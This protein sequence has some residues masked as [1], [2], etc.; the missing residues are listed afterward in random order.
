MTVILNEIVDQIKQSTDYQINRRLLREK[1]QT[2]LHFSYNNGLFKST[3]ELISFV[4]SWPYE[5][6]FLEDTYQNPIFIKKSEFLLLAVQHYQT[7][8]NSWHNQYEQIKR[9]RKI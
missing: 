6:L 8:M 2:D 4:T 1:I 5:E 3:P 9:I 7:Q